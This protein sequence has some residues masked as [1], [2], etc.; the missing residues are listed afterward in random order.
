MP[1][2]SY[3]TS[4]STTELVL[5]LSVILLPQHSSAAFPG[6]CIPVLTHV[7]W[8]LQK[9]LKDP[10][11]LL[12]SVCQLYQVSMSQISGVQL[13][14]QSLS[15]EGVEF[16]WRG[17]SLPMGESPQRGGGVTLEA[18]GVSPNLTPSLSFP[19]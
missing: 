1:D 4:F 5:E 16:P 14:E 3:L 11:Q 8:G 6:S 13:G 7:F 2:T 15:R 17:W 19:F 9:P 12:S 18:G 10:S